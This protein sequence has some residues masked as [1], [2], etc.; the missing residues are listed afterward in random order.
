MNL[1]L[2]NVIERD[3]EN[4]LRW[5]NDPETRRNST[6]TAEVSLQEH[7][8]WF[9][10]MLANYPQQVLIADL[11]GVSVGVVRLDWSEDRESCD[12][13]FTVAP[14]HRGKGCGFA[15]VEH[16]IRDIKNARVCAEVKVSDVASRRI[17]EKL[18]FHVID[19]QGELLMFAKDFG[20][21]D[22]FTRTVPGNKVVSTGRDSVSLARIAGSR[23]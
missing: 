11:D 15:I 6:N 19:S 2:R 5:R 16:A 12:L 22:H 9:A 17:F 1:F 18:E 23:R 10:T 3:S 20:G 14:E 21:F 8:R 7:A 4:L 13:S